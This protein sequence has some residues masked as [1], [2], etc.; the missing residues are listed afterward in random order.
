MATAFLGDSASGASADSSQPFER[1]AFRLD[2][3][4]Y[5]RMERTN[6]SALALES[7]T[8]KEHCQ[9][10][11]RKE[12]GNAPFSCPRRLTLRPNI[13]YKSCYPGNTSTK[14]CQMTD[15]KCWN[16][17]EDCLEAT[18]QREDSAVVPVH[19]VIEKKSVCADCYQ[20][21]RE[22]NDLG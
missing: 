2:S 11:R 19:F 10:K 12:L 21:L 20:I 9:S 6:Q 4:R 5:R 3:R 1:A 7:Q 13:W 8:S 18:S 14:L 22:L 16:C 15:S 17:G